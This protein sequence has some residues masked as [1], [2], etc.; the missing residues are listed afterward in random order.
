MSTSNPS[1]L[2]ISR[3]PPR[4][5]AHPQLA[6]TWTSRHAPTSTSGFPSPSILGPWPGDEAGSSR[7]RSSSA[8]LPHPEDTDDGVDEEEEV[9]NVVIH[10]TFTREAEMP[11]RV[12]VVVGRY[13]FWCHKEI[14][15][16]ASPFFK[17]LLEG[18]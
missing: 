9:E 16:F 4:S 8:P 13:E 3:N 10:P 5:P 12:K 7:A 15:W 2:L 17:A 1:H 18:R 14:L 6:P 11:G